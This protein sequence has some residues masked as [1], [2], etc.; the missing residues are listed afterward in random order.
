MSHG[1]FPGSLFLGSLF[2]GNLV[3]MR[4]VA[5]HCATPTIPSNVCIRGAL[6][7]LGLTVLGEDLILILIAVKSPDIT[8][9]QI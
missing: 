4:R 1:L 5:R 6:G 7:V 3:Y 8:L 2:Q 9:L